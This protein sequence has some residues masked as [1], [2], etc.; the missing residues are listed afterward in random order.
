VS[1]RIGPVE[2]RWQLRGE[3]GEK[4]EKGA[5]GQA[6]LSPRL[7][8]ALVFL[9]LL[10]SVVAL[11]AV[12]GLAS[13]TLR[14]QQEVKSECQ[15]NGDLAGLPVSENPATHEASILGVKIVSDSRV[16]WRIAGCPGKLAPAAP[17]FIKWAKFYHLPTG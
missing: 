13:T 4:G 3:Q 17:S 8:R 2:A 6:G 12:G 9:F 1:E 5:R 10:P 14:L 15:F 11:I 7:R 16:A